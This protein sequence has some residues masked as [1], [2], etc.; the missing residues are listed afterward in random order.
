MFI[1]APT[2]KW[3]RDP[4]LP[5][6][7][8]KDFGAMVVKTFGLHNI[9]PLDAHFPSTEPAYLAELREGTEKAGAH[10]ID[11]PVDLHD[12]FYDTDTARRAKSVEASKKWIDIA[13]TLG[14]PSIRLHIAGSHDTKPDVDRTAQSLRQIA[15]YAAEKNVVANLEND[16]NFTEDPFFI[17]DLI[18]KVGNPYLRALPDFCNSMMT[19][20]QD[21]NN[22]AME[23]MFK[24]AYCISH[25]K[26]SEVDEGG[27]VRTVDF[28][29]C[30]AIAKAAGYRGYFSM[31]WEG[32]GEPYAG[33]QQLIDETLKNLA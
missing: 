28:V 17:V 2:N 6:M 18:E 24:H 1:D 32:K 9:E 33:T 4:K 15:Q 19:H 16:D 11:V 7:D 12:S 14:S 13:N 31:E 10:I 30:F 5:G 25:M 26:D 20:D 22:R 8:L 21:F 23:A 3:A 27:K 29:K